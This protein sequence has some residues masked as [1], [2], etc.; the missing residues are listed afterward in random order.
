MSNKKVS[1]GLDM[2][3]TNLIDTKQ[4]KENKKF[5]YSVNGIEKIL[6][7]FL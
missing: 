1:I 4:Y 7:K 5:L 3:I 2:L 6:K